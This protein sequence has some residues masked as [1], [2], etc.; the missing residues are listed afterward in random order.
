V[1]RPAK[2]LRVGVDV[3]SVSE[4]E[5]A[6]RRFGDRYVRRTFTASEASYCRAGAPRVAAERFAA[7]IAAKEAAIKALQPT[8]RWLDWRAVEVRRHPSGHCAVHLHGSAAKLARR[9]GIGH[10]A[11]SM[12]HHGDV[13]AAVVIAVPSDSQGKR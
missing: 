9:R 12:T 10:L 13:A 1:S 6:L 5:A 8:M 4:V 3:V 11:L 2:D 7:R